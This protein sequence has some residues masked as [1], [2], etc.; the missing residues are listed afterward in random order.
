MSIAIKPLVTTELTELPELTERQRRELEYHREYAESKKQMLAEAFNFDVVEEKKR[1][2][3]NQYWDMYTYLLEQD[4]KGKNL[5]IIG[6]GFG[7]DAIN[8]A[9]AGANVSAYDLSPESIDIASAVA[10]KEGLEID[11]RVM[12]AEK[13]T[14]ADNQF[15][16]IIARDILHHVEID[17][18]MAEVKRVSKPDGMLFFN[19]VYSHSIFKKIRYSRFIDKWL[20]PKMVS[21]VY[22]TDEPYITEDEDR[23][24]EVE[25][26]QI[27]EQLGSIK[28]RSYFNV[29][30]TRLLPDQY[31]LVS[32][33]DQ[34]ILRILKPVA[35]LLGSRVIMAGVISK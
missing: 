24:T 8:L 9:K 29:F 22:R 10:E 15:D 26:K 2:W 18:T 33:I 4:L 1:R 5:L 30:V 12:P 32:M 7:E 13:L 21:F 28:K 6:C 23:L 14:Y 19:E 20:Y 16:I 34:L 27:A 35:P 17:E 11:F 3:W 31:V 25:V